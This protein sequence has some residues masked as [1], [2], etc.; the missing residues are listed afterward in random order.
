MRSTL[1][2]VLVSSVVLAEDTGYSVLLQDGGERKIDVLKVVR[3]YTSM[4]LRDAKDLIDGPKPKLVRAGLSRDEATAFLNALTAKGATAEVR[5]E[6]GHPVAP[7]VAV[8]P[9]KSERF[10]VKLE[11]WGASKIQVIKIVRER[12]GLGLAETKT[13]VESAPAVMVK[14][15][16][17]PQA[18]SMVAELI[19]VG[20][21]AVLVPAPAR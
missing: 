19:A 2:L 9:V 4:S 13:L 5:H 18:E 12:T 1:L 21:K 8:A 11:S 20:A 6:G 14:G 16:N 3:E 17:R 15:L 7:V 10:E